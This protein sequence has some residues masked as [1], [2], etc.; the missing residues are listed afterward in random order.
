M[1]GVSKSGSGT[2]NPHDTINHNYNTLEKNNYT[3]RPPTFSED[4]TEFEWWK[5]KTCTH[6]IGIDDELWD[7]LEDDIDI[8]VNG[9]GVVSDRKNIRAAK[10][11]I[12]RKHHRVRGILVDALPYS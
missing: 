6:I 10:K 3:T 7:I 4:S 12:Y 5:S 11:K 8:P 2:P 1:Y 9:V